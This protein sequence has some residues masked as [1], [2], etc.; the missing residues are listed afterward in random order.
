MTY[1]PRAI[2]L[3]SVLALLDCG[4]GGDA[5]GLADVDAPV[6]PTLAVVFKAPRSSDTPWPCQAT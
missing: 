2:A 1:H 4:G 3:A 6:G 5:D